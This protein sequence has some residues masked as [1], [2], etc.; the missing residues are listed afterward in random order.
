MS[1]YALFIDFVSADPHNWLNIYK[2]VSLALKSGREM[3]KQH[4]RLQT[5]AA[6]RF[7]AITVTYKPGIDVIS[8]TRRSGGQKAPQLLSPPPTRQESKRGKTGVSATILSPVP[9]FARRVP[10]FLQISLGH[11]SPKLLLTG[12][13]VD[14]LA[15]IL[16]LIQNV[17][18]STIWTPKIMLTCICACMH[19]CRSSS[20]MCARST[21]VHTDVYKYTYL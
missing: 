13:R 21:Y 18:I 15:R 17:N 20:T 2:H 19:E 6:K 1:R 5:C 11:R 3:D 8:Q 10:G 14:L 16:T 7:A 9:P 12:K 4:R